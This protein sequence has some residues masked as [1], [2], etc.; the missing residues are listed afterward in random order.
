MGA[1]I[2]PGKRHL[3]ASP[4]ALHRMG[5]ALTAGKPHLPEE[6]YPSGKPSERRGSLVSG[7]VPQVGLEPTTDGFL[8]IAIVAVVSFLL[9]RTI[10]TPPATLA[11]PLVPALPPLPASE[12]FLACKETGDSWTH[13]TNSSP[14]TTDPRRLD[15]PPDGLGYELEGGW[16]Q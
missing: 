11:L 1:G 7:S 12:S 6:R 10:P 15:R 4:F 5:H 14:L 16:F 9:Q 13:A 2:A 3:A 8:A